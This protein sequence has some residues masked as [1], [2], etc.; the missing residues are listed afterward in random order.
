MSQGER[1]KLEWLKRARDKVISQREAAEKIGVSERWVRKLLRRMKKQGD[2]VAVHGLRGRAS[3]RK[4]AAQTQ[5]RTIELLKQHHIRAGRETVRN[6]MM[7]AKLWRA[8]RQRIEKIHEWRQRRSRAGELVQWDTSEHAW[9]DR[10][11]IRQA[12][13]ERSRMSAAPQSGRC[14]TPPKTEA[15]RPTGEEPVDEK[16]SLDQTGESRPVRHPGARRKG[17]AVGRASAARPASRSIYPKTAAPKLHP[18][19]SATKNQNPRNRQ[20]GA[21]FDRGFGA[22]RFGASPVAAVFGSAPGSATSPKHR[23][24]LKPRPQTPPS[25]QDISTWQRIGHFYLAL[26]GTGD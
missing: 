14:T 8:K 3:N 10:C 19:S 6:W 13:P 26:T 2:S 11:A 20:L 23:I 16:L 12:L 25:K 18:G 1:D 7:E 24:H 15:R 22:F 9:L 17:H 21:R 4:I 5:Q